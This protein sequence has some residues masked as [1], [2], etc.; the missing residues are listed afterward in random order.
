MQRSNRVRMGILGFLA[1]MVLLLSGCVHIRQEI[2][3]EPNEQ[4]KAFQRITFPAETVK[5]LGEE[6]LQ[7]SQAD[8]E[9]QEKDAEARGIKAHLDMHKE[10]NGDIVFEMTME[11]KGWNLLNETVFSSQATITNTA[12]GKVTFRYDPK[13]I[14]SITSMGGSYTFVLQ[15]GAIHSSNAT[16]KSGGTHTWKDPTAPMEAELTPGVSGGGFPVWAIVVL[17]V[18]AV[19]IMAVV[20]F[21]LLYMRG[22]QRQQVQIPPPPPASTG[23]PPMA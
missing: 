12:G 20:A 15:G 7:S 14:T 18:V 5:Q 4:W 22:K 1:V 6:Q 10:G 16:E 3:L 11:G 8:F 17:V 23:T 19:F 2:T 21:V 9:K 13:E